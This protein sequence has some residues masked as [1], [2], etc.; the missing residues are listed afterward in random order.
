MGS[1]GMAGK[2]A[3]AEVPLGHGVD[4]RGGAQHRPGAGKRARRRAR[5]RAKRRFHRALELAG[6]DGRGR[7]ARR[8]R[9]L[10]RLCL[11]LD[12]SRKAADQDLA[13]LREE[14]RSATTR[15]DEGIKAMSQRVTIQTQL[16]DVRFRSVGAS[17]AGEGRLPVELASMDEGC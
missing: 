17:Y 13:R 1:G 16:L 7:R 3:S 8:G 12:E 6:N 9:F 5:Q 2:A 14:V 4:S 11:Q 15:A 10:E